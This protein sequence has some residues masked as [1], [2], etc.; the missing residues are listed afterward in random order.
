MLDVGTMQRP[1]WSSQK[2]RNFPV[3]DARCLLANRHDNGTSWSPWKHDDR[4]VSGEKVYLRITKGDGKNRR[5]QVPRFNSCVRACVRVCVHACMCTRI[6]LFPYYFLSSFSHFLFL[7][8]RFHFLTLRPPWFSWS[9][10]RRKGQIVR[11]DSYLSEAGRVVFFFF[12]FSTSS[13]YTIY[14]TNSS[15]YLVFVY[16]TYQRVMCVSRRATSY[17]GGFARTRKKKIKADE[18]TSTSL[19]SAW[20]FR[21]T[22][23]A[24]VPNVYGFLVRNFEW[25]KNRE[26][27]REK[28][29]D[30]QT[31]RDRQRERE[32]ERKRKKN[33]YKETK[34]RYWMCTRTIPFC[35][36][37]EVDDELI[38]IRPAW[39]LRFNY[40]YRLYM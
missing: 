13:S 36:F 15:F 7:S 11:N 35:F 17:A 33:R 30:R 21:Y 24:C 2:I 32:R 14:R 22:V 9:T 37:L 38:V 34:E 19:N 26:R 3:R 1:V 40:A 27:E 12:F 31:D 25:R 6:A 16:L 10:R 28:E 23:C 20:R 8:F 4:A 5:G 39:K 18:R 29:R